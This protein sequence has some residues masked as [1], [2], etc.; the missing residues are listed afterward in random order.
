MSGPSVWG[1][2]AWKLLHTLA[3][4]SDHKDFYKFWQKIMSTLVGCM[5]CDKCRHHLHKQLMTITF[6]QGSIQDQ[7]FAVHNNV[8]VQ[9][10]K[11]EFK[12]EDL[13]MYAHKDIYTAL[14]ASKAL[15]EQLIELWKHNVK[16]FKLFSEWKHT[17]NQLMLNVHAHA[18]EERKP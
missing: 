7:L 4:V 6:T 11:P 1:P 8:N 17:V 10:G 12:H 13:A 9:N 3:T 14:D 5:P 2:V 16:N 18:Q 15:F